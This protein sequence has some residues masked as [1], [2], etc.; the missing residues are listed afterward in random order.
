MPM[1]ACRSES[2]KT[3]ESNQ[4]PFWLY[5]VDT[6]DTNYAV[7]NGGINFEYKKFQNFIPLSSWNLNPAKSPLYFIHIS[8]GVGPKFL[9]V[10]FERSP[11]PPPS[12]SL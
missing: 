7:L 11:R 8:Q 12:N 2:F 4:E 10:N 6:D 5:L 1:A 9:S 3:G